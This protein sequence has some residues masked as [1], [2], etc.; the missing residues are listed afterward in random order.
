MPQYHKELGTHSISSIHCDGLS[1]LNLY[2]QNVQSIKN[3]IDTLEFIANNNNFDVL[4]LSE[5]GCKS[6]ELQ[7]ADLTNFTLVADS[8]RT[9]HISGGIVIYVNDRQ[10]AHSTS[11][12]WVKNLNAEMDIEVAGVEI[13]LKATMENKKILILGIYRSPNGNYQTFIN[14]FDLLLEI[15]C[16]KY[17]D[18]FILGDFN[19]NG[20]TINQET[21]QFKDIL[22]SFGLESIIKSPTRVTDHSSTQIDYI[23][24]NK[25]LSY[26]AEIVDYHI[27]DHF[28]QTVL[29]PIK[30]KM[31]LLLNIE[32]FPNLT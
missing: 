26:E 7:A 31:K 20:M 13:K 22:N 17:R 4:V 24:T 1:K 29:I 15:A 3:K 9:D 18:I 19:I 27:S 21:L 12:D 28:G 16:H 32:T 8:C 30:L 11:I 14:K 10:L 6:N 2:H 25:T 5:H 23:I